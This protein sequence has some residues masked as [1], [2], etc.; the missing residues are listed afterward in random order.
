MLIW[1]FYCTGTPDCH[2]KLCTHTLW[3]TL[4][5]LSQLLCAFIINKHGLAGSLKV[6]FTKKSKLEQKYTFELFKWWPIKHHWN[7]EKCITCANSM[8]RLSLRIPLITVINTS[9]IY[10]TL[11]ASDMKSSLASYTVNE[12][13]DKKKLVRSIKIRVF[14]F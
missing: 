2:M 10:K 12:N 6:I 1:N 3:H 8:S 14:S 7:N 11:W 4:A 13:E 5:P 9:N